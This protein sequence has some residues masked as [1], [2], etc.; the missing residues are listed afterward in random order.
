[1]SHDFFP[2]HFLH[3]STQGKQKPNPQEMHGW[4]TCQAE[5]V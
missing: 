3:V 4:E 5:M 2:E 1:M